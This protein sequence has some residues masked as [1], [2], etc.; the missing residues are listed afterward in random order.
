[1][2]APRPNRRPARRGPGGGS[3]GEFASGATPG[4]TPGAN[5]SAGRGPNVNGVPQPPAGDAGSD[6]AGQTMRFTIAS[7]FDA[8][9]DIQRWVMDHL[10]HNGYSDDHVFAIR[11]SLEEALV[12]A[13]KHG[14][15]LDPRK[16]VH[17]EAT[18]TPRRAEFTIE[19]EGPGFDRGRIP[20]PTAEENLCKCS[21]RGILLIES[22]MNRAE[23][24]KGGRRLRMV[25]ENT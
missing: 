20:D 15:G 25:K 4:A 12:N 21:G 10:E 24:T 17:V 23:W 9:R 8:G 11:I 3:A 19:D 5:G 2:G 13:I 22:Y 1:M 7:D 6:G 14:N 16:K 18:V